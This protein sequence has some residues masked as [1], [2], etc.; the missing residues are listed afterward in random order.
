MKIAHPEEEGKERGW[1]SLLRPRGGRKTAGHP[2]DSIRG[3][4]ILECEE[5]NKN[6]KVWAADCFAVMCSLVSCVLLC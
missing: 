2:A 5:N 1:L 4:I 6:N 3:L